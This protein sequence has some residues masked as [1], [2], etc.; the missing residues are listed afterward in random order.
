MSTKKKKMIQLLRIQAIII[1]LI[2][3]CI[4]S[5]S[6]AIKVTNFVSDLHEQKQ[7][8]QTSL[9]L[10]NE[11]SNDEYQEILATN[12]N[13]VFDGKIYYDF[14]GKKV[15]GDERFVN[16]SDVIVDDD[17][18]NK[19]KNLWNV[20]VVSL[21]DE[22]ISNERKKLLQEEFPY[23]TFQWKIPIAGDEFDY[24]IQHLD[25]SHKKNLN[26][27][28]LVVAIKLFPALE[29]IDLSYCNLS[30]EELGS[31]RELFPNM[32][33]HWVVHLGKWSLR[34][35]SI[36]FSVLIYTYDYRRMTSNDIQ[37]LKYCTKLQ[38]LDLG[39]QDIVDISVI[40]DYLPELR[41]LILADNKIKDIS[42]I[43]K[44]KHLHYL[45]L[46]MNDITDVT[47]L[48]NCKEMVDL[49][50]SFNPHFSNI[51]GIL[52]YPLLE[53]LWLVSN[54][55]PEA[56]Y[57]KIKETYPNV[58]LV[59]VGSGS[60]GSGWRT[61]E[62]YFAMIDMYHNNYISESFTQYDNANS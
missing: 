54:R 2:F 42:P 50:I 5:K 60:T 47:P 51:D 17:L 24:Q 37:V 25:L 29:S 20:E 43:G 16:L 45:E 56:S 10:P 19:L 11:M 59:K 12:P 22:N 61:H 44:L 27:Q 15:Y 21:Y 18:E 7:T 40:G 30:N 32:E 46:F 39:H 62:R 35:D 38:A 26:F 28:D 6:M 23:I 41:V 3:I 52:E 31:L 9:D 34:T 53:R 13:F 49:N 57:R 48:A 1:I 58:E 8:K 33:I 55:I 4:S 36:A 14:Y